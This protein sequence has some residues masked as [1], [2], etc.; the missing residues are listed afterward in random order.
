MKNTIKL[1]VKPDLSEIADEC[2]KLETSLTHAGIG[3]SPAMKVRYIAHE[4]FVNV[5]RH[6]KIDKEADNI[7]AEI[8]IYNNRIELHFVD[9][10][11]EWLPDQEVLRQPCHYNSDDELYAPSGKGLRLIGA[12]CRTYSMFRDNGRNYTSISVEL[13]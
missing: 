12:M 7:T 5:V 9:S 13:K 2:E 10:G 6:G 11:R 4:F 1:S 3:A 8:D